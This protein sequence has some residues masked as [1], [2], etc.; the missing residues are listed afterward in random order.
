MIMIS[1]I[2]PKKD[3]RT[4]HKMCTE[5][6]GYEC[7]KKGKEVICPLS[8]ILHYKCDIRKKNLLCIACYTCSRI[9]SYICI[10]IYTHMHI[11][12][13]VYIYTQIL[14]CLYIYIYIR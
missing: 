1:I 10:Y 13:Y 5:V 7:H 8:N 14:I 4:W 9:Y 2:P 11:C 12:I 6:I 3:I